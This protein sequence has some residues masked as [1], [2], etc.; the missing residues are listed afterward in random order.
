MSHSGYHHRAEAVMASL[1]ASRE[2]K[3]RDKPVSTKE[4]L[5]RYRAAIKTLQ[6][7]HPESVRRHVPED[8][9]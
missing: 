1:N 2:H 9:R 6:R 8:L 7:L 4:A 3:E 5:K